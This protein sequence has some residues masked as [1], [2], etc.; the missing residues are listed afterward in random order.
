MRRTSLSV[1]LLAW[2]LALGAQ[3]GQLPDNLLGSP[4]PAAQ[5]SRAITIGPQTR[6]VNVQQGEV[7]RFV[8][9]GQEFAF[10]FDSPNVASF[11][12]QRVAPAGMLDHSV[13]AYVAPAPDGGGGRGMR[14]GHGGR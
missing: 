12:L 11:D 6:Y 9:N 13:M 2:A 7:V 10:K 5:A 1:G 8:V 4:M 3:G 14:G